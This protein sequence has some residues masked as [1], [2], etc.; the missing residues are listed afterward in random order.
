MGDDRFRIN[1]RWCLKS[2]FPVK[3]T[4][5]SQRIRQPANLICRGNYKY[6]RFLYIINAGLHSHIFRRVTVGTILVG[7]FIHVIKEDDGGRFF[8][9]SGERLFDTVDKGVAAFVPPHCNGV[10]SAF[11]YKTFCQ[12]A[13]A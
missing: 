3:S 13:L 8:L 1:R 5:T 9:C 7:E 10:Q 11:F 4:G 2:D 6:I 12:Q